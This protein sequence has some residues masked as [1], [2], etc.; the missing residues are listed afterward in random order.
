MLAS[1]RP[2]SFTVESSTAFLSPVVQMWHFFIEIVVEGWNHCSDNTIRLVFQDFIAIGNG[3]ICISGNHHKV[4][5]SIQNCIYFSDFVI[6][7][8]KSYQFSIL[9]RQTP[10]WQL[11]VMTLFWVISHTKLNFSPMI[12][13]TDCLHNQ[14]LCDEWL[15]SLLF[16]YTSWNPVLGIVT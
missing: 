7:K 15:V 13:E 10:P 1:K 4:H 14:K 12:M 8:R 3:I 11:C 16:M 5:I 6:L 9:I 2:Y